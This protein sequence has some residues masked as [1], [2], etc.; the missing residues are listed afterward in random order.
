M[1]FFKGWAEPVQT[2]IQ[3]L[4]PD[5]TNRVLIHDI[6][7]LDTLVRGRVALWETLGIAPLPI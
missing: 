1:R 4:E 6:D 3:R 2:L 5:K 7:P